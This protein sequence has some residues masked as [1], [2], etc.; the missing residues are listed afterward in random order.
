MKV[1]KNIMILMLIVVL[2]VAISFVVFSYVTLNNDN[3]PIEELIHHQYYSINNDYALS[4]YSKSAIYK[5]PDTT[6]VFDDYLYS[7]NFLQLTKDAIT[8][9]FIVLDK[10]LL[11]C[12]ES[13][14]YLYVW[15]IAQ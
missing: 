9:N 10:E 7:E 1:F 13:N 2:I 3:I 12:L 4:I 14:M 8:Y 5:T 6:L 15:E 11:F